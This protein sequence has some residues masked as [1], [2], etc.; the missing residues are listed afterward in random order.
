MKNPRLIFIICVTILVAGPLG[1]VYLNGQQDH[2][3]EPVERGRGGE[4]CRNVTGRKQMPRN[5][6]KI[7][8]PAELSFELISGEN[9][10]NPVTMLISALSLVPVESGKIT[11]KIPQIGE[12]TS[13][14]MELWSG[15]PAD[16]VS[17]SMDYVMDALPV[18]NYRFVVIFE[19]LPLGKIETLGFSKSL[20]LDVRQEKILSSN[21]S[22]RQIKRIELME[23]LKQSA[24]LSLRPELQSTDVQAQA[25]EI[26]AIESFDPGMLKR[27]IEEL[28]NTDPEVA[29]KIRELNR[30]RI[31]TEQESES[32]GLVESANTGSG[33]EIKRTSF[34]A[35]RGQPA[36]ERQVSVPEY[37]KK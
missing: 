33:D 37:L 20:Y 1:L 19:F 7:K 34:Q 29:K 16:F 25:R 28:K 6:G 10:K 5:Y 4:L 2:K 21:V 30:I 18:G 17:E 11:L 9:P 23:E 3:I 24:L 31:G 22:F 15:K 12:E 36:S 32:Q 14:R 27:K 13:E 8:V 35:F 26:A